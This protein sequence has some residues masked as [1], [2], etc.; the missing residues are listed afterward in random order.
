MKDKKAY[1][2]LVPD[3]VLVAD[4]VKCMADSHDSSYVTIQKTEY[5]AKHVWYIDAKSIK[6]KYELK[7]IHY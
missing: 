2:Y 3:T 1:A 5:K 6:T 7:E 4:N